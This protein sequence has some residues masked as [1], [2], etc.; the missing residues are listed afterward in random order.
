MLCCVQCRAGVG[1]CPDTLD[2]SGTCTNDVTLVRGFSEDGQQ[3]VVFSRNFAAGKL[4]RH[5]FLLSLH[6][7]GVWCNV[8]CAGDDEC[9]L[10]L[11]PDNE[12]QYIVWGVG[13][14]GE[15]AFRHFIRAQCKHIHTHTHAHTHT[16]T[17]THTQ[18]SIN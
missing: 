5:F 15:T 2:S 11:D 4:G 12:D 9:D 14:L 18:Y 16:H 7:C 3:C 10:P 17:H 13:G 8:T 6:Y 1:A